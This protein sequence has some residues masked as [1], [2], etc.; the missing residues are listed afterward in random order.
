MSKQ[1]PSADNRTSRGRVW[2]AVMPLLLTCGTG[3]SVAAADR[4]VATCP[5]TADAARRLVVGL[6]GAP[7]AVSDDYE[8][9]RYPGASFIVFGLRPGA[10]FVRQEVDEDGEPASMGIHFAFPASSGLE[11]LRKSFASSFGN[12]G[13]VCEVGC[14]WHA[15]S[16]VRHGL[17][18]AD[19]VGPWGADPDSI[20]LSCNYDEVDD[21][22]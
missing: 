15:G 18:S 17:T 2:T 10:V 7:E 21:D 20:T 13:V 9:T 1:S 11:R 14:E 3:N 6:Q 16:G 4:V 8:E 5:A 22:E 12:R 19:L